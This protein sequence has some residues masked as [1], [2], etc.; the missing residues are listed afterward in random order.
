MP[1]LLKGLCTESV[2]ESALV[3]SQPHVE[4]S[5]S[6]QHLSPES[7]VGLVNNAVIVIAAGAS[8]HES[9]ILFL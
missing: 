3:E 5:R 7:L 6:C 2:D 8:W 4:I 9:V 1:F